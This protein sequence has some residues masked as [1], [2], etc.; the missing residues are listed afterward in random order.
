[1]KN[2]VVAF[3]LL[4]SIVS[5]QNKNEVD[6]KSPYHTIHT[7]LYYLQEDTFDIQKFPSDWVITNPDQSFTWERTN[8]TVGGQLQQ[9]VYIRHYEYDGNGELDYF[10]SPIIDL[11]KYPN[12]PAF[13]A[14]KTV[15]SS[16]KLVNTRI[17]TSGFS[18][19]IS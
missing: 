4:T 15:S 10:I 19:F 6:L 17:R 3:L 9:A 8:I 7:H 13:M 5:A 1:M 16:L 12:A 14:A 18:A 11:S 2:L